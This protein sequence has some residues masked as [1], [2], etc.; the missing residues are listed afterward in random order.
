MPLEI[1]IKMI[2]RELGKDLNTLGEKTV[3]NLK[4]A[5]KQLSQNV[6]AEADRLAGNKLHSSA[7]MYRSS[8]KYQS[9][10]NDVYVVYLDPSTPAKYFEDGWSSFDMKAGLLNGP[11]A[12]LSPKGTKYNI[13]PL[14]QKPFSKTKSSSLVDTRGAI[15]KIIQDKSIKK[16]IKEFDNGNV[17]VTTYQ[18]IENPMLKGLTK[19]T[20]SYQN[21]KQSQ[22]F[23]FRVVSSKSDPSSWIHPGFQPGAQ[24][25]KELEFYVVEN[26]DR[27]VKSLI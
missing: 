3:N 19:I 22:Y 17:S 9:F 7:E 14:Q 20:K 10:S 4:Q 21:A 2:A 23:I 1:D 12:R 5:V 11:K 26:I 25:F 13:V 27:I 16:E 18:G 24:I 15:L 6:Y 8:L